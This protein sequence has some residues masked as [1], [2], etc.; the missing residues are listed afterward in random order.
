MKKIDKNQEYIVDII[1]NG[2]QAEGI[3]RIDDYTVFIPNAIK[4]EKVKILIVKANKSYGYGKILEILQESKD[5]VEPRCAAYKRCGGCSMQHIRYNKQLE[6]KKD[7]VKNVIKKEL[8]KEVTIED[9]IGM[10]EMCGYRNKA[11]YALGFNKNGESVYGFFAGR[12]HEIIPS[13]KCYIQNDIVDEVSK[14]VFYLLNKYNMPIYNESTQKGIFRHILVKI[15]LKTNQIMVVFI[16]KD[17]KFPNKKEIID[18]LTNKY[19]NIRSIVQNINNKVTNTILGDKNILLYG[20]EYIT[21]ILGEYKFKISLLSFYQVNPFQT[22]KLYNKAIEFA[23]FTGTE[24]VY[25]LYCGIGT[26]SLFISKYAK[27]V[28]GIEVVPEAIEDAKENAKLNNVENAEFFVGEVEKVLPKMY[29]QGKKADIVF[30]D[31]PRKGLD[32]TTISTILS[33]EPKKIIYISCNPATLA[34]DLKLLG[35][36][37]AIKKVQPVD[38]FPNTSHVECVAVLQ[39]K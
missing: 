7:M 31:P 33:I 3:A 8:N 28:Y 18:E 24:V 37:Y 32:N 1:D 4:G 34:R 21:D 26:I 15:G 10:E 23:D 12:T 11:K 6:I 35:E 14:Y 38:M 25:D 30:V 29:N 39:L 19:K 22:E 17:K 5:R 9:V 36:K 13:N 2:F 27:K 16:T 20:E